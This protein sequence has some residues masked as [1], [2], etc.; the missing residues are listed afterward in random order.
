MVQ[1]AHLDSFLRLLVSHMGT[2]LSQGEMMIEGQSHQNR[3]DQLL[4]AIEQIDCNKAHE[5]SIKLQRNNE[6][7]FVQQMQLMREWVDQL[8]CFDPVVERSIDEFLASTL[9]MENLVFD[10]HH[11]DL[12]NQLNIEAVLVAI[13]ELLGR[14]E[15]QYD[16]MEIMYDD[17]ERQ[18]VNGVSFRDQNLTKQSA[19]IIPLFSKRT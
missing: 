7:L 10:H 9:F 1:P 11:G 14:L 5:K 15:E 2:V 18:V 4:Y 16:M 17:E 3:M 6:I 12:A 8:G 13:F 19:K